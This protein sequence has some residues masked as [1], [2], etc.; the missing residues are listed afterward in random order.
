MKLP[1]P[2]ASSIDS[3]ARTAVG[4]EWA[5]YATLIEH[6]S[7]IVG[8]DYAQ[9]TKP[10]KI[11]FPK[12][13]KAGENWARHKQ[14]GGTLLIRLPHGLRM[15]FSFLIPQML[16]RINAFFGYPAIATLQ[17]DS[18]YEKASVPPP[19][20]AQEKTLTDREKSLLKEQ[21]KDIDNNEL[22]EALERLGESVLREHS[23]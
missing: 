20:P 11:S 22:R 6:W 23:N 1:R 17:F 10:V 3:V 13:K 7:E 18:Y 12:G 4:K 5:L 15:E 19:P 21:L 9:K 14:T 8:A 16:Q 2:L